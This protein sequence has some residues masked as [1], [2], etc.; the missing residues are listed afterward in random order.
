LGI[1]R[2]P[3]VLMIENYCTGQIWGIMR[4]CPYLVA[5]LRRAGFTGGW[6]YSQPTQD[7]LSA[8]AVPIKS[9]QMKLR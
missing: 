7:R 2:G 3:V 5:R 6:R 1:D 8:Q 9:R 4:R